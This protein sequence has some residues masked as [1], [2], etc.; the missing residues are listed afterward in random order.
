MSQDDVREEE[1]KSLRRQRD[2][3]EENLRLIHE[4][5]AE[6]PLSTDVPIHL[7]KEGDCA[8]QSGN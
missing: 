5:K 8:T 7:I 6:Y 1:L 2:E 3:A 4:R